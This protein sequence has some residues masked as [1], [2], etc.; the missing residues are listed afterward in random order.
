M[1]KK[2]IAYDSLM[3][4]MLWVIILILAGLSL[5]FLFKRFGLR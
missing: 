2:G 3:N 1:H 5:Y 4:I